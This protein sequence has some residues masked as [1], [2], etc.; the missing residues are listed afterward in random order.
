MKGYR[1]LLPPRNHL[2]NHAHCERWVS[3]KDV[4]AHFNV[5]LGTMANR[6]NKGICPMSG[7]AG[8]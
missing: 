8:E 7:L 5:S 1:K 2:S 6:M 4:A 3:K